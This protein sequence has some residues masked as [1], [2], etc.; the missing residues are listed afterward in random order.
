LVLALL[1]A[2]LGGVIEGLAGVVR[3]LDVDLA[4]LM[5]AV[6]LLI[7]WGLAVL[8]LSDWAAGVLIPLLGFGSV[9][10]RVG[11][12]DTRLVPLFQTLFGLYDGVL[13]WIYGGSLPDAQPV[14]LALV[15]LWSGFVTLLDRARVWLLAV[16]AGQ[17]PADPVAMMLVW[18]LILSAVC[19]WAGWMVRRH[20]QVLPGIAPAGALL[21]VTLSYSGG[22]ISTLLIL[23]AATL[24]LLTLIAYDA[25]MR[26]WKVTQTDFA[27]LAYEVIVAA[28]SL[29]FVLVTAA[30][31]VPTVSWHDLFESAR[32]FVTGG[33]HGG[34]SGSFAEAM[35]VQSAEVA[36]TAFDDVRAGGLPR[37]HLLGSGPELSQ[38]IVMIIST[39]DLLPGPPQ[40]YDTGMPA[41]PRYYWRGV[42]YDVY[43]RS[44]WYAG[45]LETIEYA[46]DEPIITP[47]LNAQRVVHQNVHV[48]GNTGGLLYAA[49]DLIA[50][51]QPYS[52]A[53]RS[54]GDV[55]AAMV[56]TTTYRAESVVS[57]ASGE[58]LRAAGDDYPQWVRDRYLVVPDAVP[59]RVVAL[60]RSL[61]ATEPTPYD[62]ARA[63]EAY[64]RTIPYSLDVPLP[65]FTRDVVDYFL[66]DLRKGY[67]DYYAT[68]MVVLARAAGLPARMAVGYVSGFYD[69]VRA[70]YVVTEAS[71]HAWPEIY[72]PGYGWIEFE[73]TAGLPPIERAEIVEPESVGPLARLGSPAVWRGRLR[74]IGWSALWGLAPMAAAAIAA[75]SLA[76]LLRLRRLRP[77]AAVTEVYRRLR[78]RG[79]W[80][81]V[82]VRVADT[83][84]EFAA[85]FADRIAALVRH[86]YSG[87]VLTPAA[88]E[89][90]SLTELYVQSSYSARVLDVADRSRAIRTWLR[91]LWRLWL[92]RL[93]RI[94]GL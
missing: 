36:Q 13:R 69:P 72:F 58:E 71:A 47:T 75:W 90:R 86:E 56:E 44:G 46:A 40:G 22:R 49:G 20:S 68:A 80:L 42:T 61:T 4:L 8:S 70:E 29:T 89:A 87:Q 5:A 76:D 9:L 91:L 11:R 66:F 43:V 62:R 53:W 79:R 78:R 94:L 59:A 37:R 83:P 52:V 81:A 65:P 48:V 16:L 7:G 60:A 19:A 32:E 30:G 88:Q 31:I 77:A 17:S 12:L 33:D 64:L 57:T 23:L 28:F 74:R 24:L 55:F 73:P 92:A 25:R 82:P 93:L 51:N 3:G 14:I 2:A 21:V 10:L 45:S 38:K 18:S 6:G 54:S 84:Y 35:G 67:C 50:A 26:H 34:R 15:E 1:A 27:D 39:G 63:I 41:P 85:L